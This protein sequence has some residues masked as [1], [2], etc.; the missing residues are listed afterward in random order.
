MGALPSAR[1]GAGDEPRHRRAGD[2]ARAL[3]GG[4][5]PGI[6]AK[7]VMSSMPASNT[8]VYNPGSGAMATCSGRI[9]SV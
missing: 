8:L 6:P 3:P 4:R 2:V 9:D 7:K 5:G 1:H